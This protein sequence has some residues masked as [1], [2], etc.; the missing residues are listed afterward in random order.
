MTVKVAGSS[1][2]GKPLNSEQLQKVMIGCECVLTLDEKKKKLLQY[3]ES[4]MQFLAPNLTA[5]I[6]A[7]VGSRLI[8]AAGGLD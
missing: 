2:N 7:M 3:I 5:F 6:G 1:T 4:R 8:A